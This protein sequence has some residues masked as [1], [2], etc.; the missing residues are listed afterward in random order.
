MDC[1]TCAHNFKQKYK[2]LTIDD[3]KKLFKEYKGKAKFILGDKEY[4][5]TT[6]GIVNFSI[7]LILE[8]KD[9]IEN[10]I[11]PLSI[12][13]IKKGMEHVPYLRTEEVAF[14]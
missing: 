8:P 13:R 1:N 10:Y 2:A 11:K 3:Y 12:K 9:K 4:R 7:S 5:A 6:C 14:T